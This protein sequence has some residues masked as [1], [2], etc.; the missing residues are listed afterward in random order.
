M[1]A[2]I[3]G[4]INIAMKVPSHE[5]EATVAF[6]RDTL[7]LKRIDGKPDDV[8]FH[9]GPN[10]LWID[11]CPS[12]SQAEIWLEL[13]C[14]EF[15]EAARDMAAH[16]VTRCDAIEPLPAGF[17]G[18]WLMNPANVVHMLREEDAW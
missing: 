13:F 15:T 4:G 3:R 14:D 10:H 8:G 16:K 12:L 2:N 11:R 9:F 17:K 5:Y 18:G 1:S 6:Y 7:A